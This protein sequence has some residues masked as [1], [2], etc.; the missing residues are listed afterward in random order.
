MY[1]CKIL[2]RKAGT[3]NYKNSLKEGNQITARLIDELANSCHATDKIE[4]KIRVFHNLFVFR[5]DYIIKN[6]AFILGSTLKLTSYA[7]YSRLHPMLS[8]YLS[9][10]IPFHQASKT[11]SYSKSQS[12]N[13]FLAM[14]F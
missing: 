10:Q 14:L 11:I 5:T 12:N 8:A 7:S 13:P 1:N 2:Y 6:G 9:T 4:K 3:Q